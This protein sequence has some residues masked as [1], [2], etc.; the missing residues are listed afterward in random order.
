MQERSL[1][2][3]SCSRDK[4]PDGERFDHSARRMA[5]RAH[6]PHRWVEFIG[7]RS[8]IFNLLKGVNGR[9]RNIDQAGGFCDERRSN[10]N[11]LPGPD[12][13][14]TAFEQP[15]FL[16]AYQRYCGRFFTEL[17]CVK[18]EFWEELTSHPAVD[19]LFVSGLYGLVFWNDEI[20]E[21]DCHFGDCLEGREHKRTVA[22]LGIHC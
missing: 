4:R 8:R 2:L 13:G 17:T 5:S 14:G 7:G 1:I 19:I 6:I 3:L 21:Y 18:R 20:Q 22:D 9:L 10:K 12:F 15:I 16:P 11:L